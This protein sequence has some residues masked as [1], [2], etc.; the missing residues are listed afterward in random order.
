MGRVM[1]TNKPL[2]RQSVGHCSPMVIDMMVRIFKEE[3][4][5]QTIAQ[6]VFEHNSLTHAGEIFF[7]CFKTSESGFPRLFV[8]PKSRETFIKR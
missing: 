3:K 1:E 8:P 6:Y 4:T 7:R 2:M 5:F